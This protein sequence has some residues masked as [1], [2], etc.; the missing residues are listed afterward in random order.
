MTQ[1]VTKAAP[2]AVLHLDIEELVLL[3]GPEVANDVGMRGQPCDSLDLVHV[4]VPL[5]LAAEGAVA[6]LDGE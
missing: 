2:L 6:L 1:Q 4:L 3:P 5:Q